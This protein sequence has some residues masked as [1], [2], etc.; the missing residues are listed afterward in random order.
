MLHTCSGN[1]KASI[2]IGRSHRARQILSVLV[3]LYCLLALNVCLTLDVHAICVV[4]VIPIPPLRYTPPSSH[5]AFGVGIFI[6]RRSFLHIWNP[7]AIS[8]HGRVFVKPLRF[9]NNC[10]H[11]EPRGSPNSIH[12]GAFSRLLPTI[13]QHPKWTQPDSEIEPEWIQ[14]RFKYKDN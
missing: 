2:H 13:P 3:L 11:V 6:R 5:T 4:F 12:F 9:M 8:P 14:N 10:A 1:S 7:R